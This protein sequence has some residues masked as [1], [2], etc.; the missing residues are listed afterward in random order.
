MPGRRNR[1]AA[2]DH[3]LESTAEA[4][5]GPRALEPEAL[6]ELFSYTSPSFWD[7]WQAF[8]QLPEELQTNASQL[9]LMPSRQSPSSSL[10][11]SANLC[12]TFLSKSSSNTLQPLADS[13]GTK[14]VN[15]EVSQVVRASFERIDP[16]IRTLLQ[17]GHV[18]PLLKQLELHIEELQSSTGSHQQLELTLPNARDRMVAHGVAQFYGLHHRSHNTRDN[19]RVTILQADRTKSKKSPPVRL[20]DLVLVST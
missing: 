1:R 7:S 9:A 18:E 14:P 8:A 17:Q 3:L 19:G 12:T 10:R 4:L 11:A 5:S 2:N 20:S 13:H 15:E 6:A 16:P